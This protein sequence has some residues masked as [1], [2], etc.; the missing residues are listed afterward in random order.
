MNGD[1]VELG[2]EREGKIKLLIIFPFE[3]KSADH[4]M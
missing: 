1:A 4:D 3:E 2:R